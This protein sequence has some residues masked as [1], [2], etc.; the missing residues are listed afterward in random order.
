M[1]SLILYKPDL[2]I[3]RTFRLRRKKQRI[4]E[5][6]HAAGRNSSIV[7]EERRT[8]RDFVTPGVQGISS[9][10]ARP[11]VDANNFELKP[12]LISMVQQSQYTFRRPKPTPLS[13]FRGGDMLKLNGVSSDAIYL[14]LFPFSLRDKVRAWL[15]SLPT[16]CI[17]T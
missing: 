11:A 14:R 9:S 12:A 1:R 10:I 15:H 7:G 2:E 5:Q 13:I 4:E 6:R 16:G 17:I 8:L 3:E